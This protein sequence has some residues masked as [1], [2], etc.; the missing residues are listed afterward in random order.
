MKPWV[1][2]LLLLAACVKALALEP[3]IS[4]PELCANSGVILVGRPTFRLD[5]P[6]PPGWQTNHQNLAKIAFVPEKALKGANVPSLIQVI[7]YHNPII[8]C[9][10]GP[11]FPPGQRLVAF[12]NTSDSTNYYAYGLSDSVKELKGTNSNALLARIEEYAN[13]REDSKSFGLRKSWALKC[14]EDTTTQ[15]EG[16]AWLGES[17][18]ALTHDEKA[19]ILESFLQR[20]HIGV[21]DHEVAG[22]IYADFPRQ[23]TV[24][25]LK[26]LDS[27][28][29]LGTTN[30][31][32]SN[33]QLNGLGAVL[34]AQFVA[35]K[36][37]PKL[38]TEAKA[39]NYGP[40]ARKAVIQKLL[41]R[42]Q[43]K[44]SMKYPNP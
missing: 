20:Q 10:A 41:P 16:L 22:I 26:K 19:S 38:P 11:S 14:L 17:G 28:V 8:A 12:F 42:L 6:E 29:N 1:K 7:Y 9:P 34:L 40:S 37:D 32:S 15:R 33:L 39:I 35:E 30:S 2:P 3:F 13:I 27:F 44:A 36:L 18:A 31:D 21:E 24:G 43:A 5:M 25:I 23:T 4:V